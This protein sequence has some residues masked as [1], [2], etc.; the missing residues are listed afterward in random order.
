[1]RA[2]ISSVVER[3]RSRA[4][5]QACRGLFLKIYTRARGSIEQLRDGDA[6]IA[7]S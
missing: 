5:G 1:M 4:R 2:K 7:D 3:S 6:G